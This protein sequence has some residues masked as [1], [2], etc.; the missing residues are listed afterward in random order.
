MWA[1]PEPTELSFQFWWF[2]YTSP[3]P[4]TVKLGLLFHTKFHLI[5]YKFDDL[6]NYTKTT[7]SKFKG[8]M[9]RKG[10]GSL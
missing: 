10:G 3:S 4:I 8:L 9:A 6:S 7:L 2:A 1:D 5:R